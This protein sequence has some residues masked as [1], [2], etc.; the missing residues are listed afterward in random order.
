MT[1]KG[2]CVLNITPLGN[3]HKVGSTRLVVY[4]CSCLCTL[5]TP[6][7]STSV[8]EMVLSV[9]LQRKMETRVVNFE[10]KHFGEVLNKK[11]TRKPIGFDRY[12]LEKIN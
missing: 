5:G 12:C 8:V 7:E 1:R 9:V 6:C 3:N 11:S 10:N 2:S 4:T